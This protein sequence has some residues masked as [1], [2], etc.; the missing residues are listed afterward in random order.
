[1]DHS[2]NQIT[3]TKEYIKELL[4]NIPHSP[5]VYKMKNEHGDIIYVGK[6]KD[7]KNR[8]SSYF[9]ASQDKTTKTI[10]M[11][12]Q[13][14]DIDIITVQSELEAIML[15]T[16]LIK[17]YRPKY[18]ILMKDDKYFVYLKITVNEAFPRVEIVRKIQNDKAKYFGP[19]TAKYKILDALKVLKKIFPFRH[20]NLN[21]TYN[22][23]SDPRV[24]VSNASI[25]YPCLDYHINRCQA[26]CIGNISP[27]DYR[28]NINNIIDFF[29]GNQSK[30]IW[31]LKEKMMS[32]AQNKKFEQAAQIRD[33]I[34]SIEDLSEKQIISTTNLN[35][36]DIINFA[37][38]DERIFFNLFSVRKGKL[39]DQE[40][41]IFQSS[42]LEAE[43]N[44]EIV[45]AF[46]SQYYAE[47][48]DLPDEILVPALP[49][50]EEKNALEEWLREKKGKK[51]KL[52]SP[53]RGE[54]DQ[55]LELSFKNALSY[56]KQC[57]IK[58]LGQKKNERITALEDLKQILNLK[59]LPNRIECYDISHIQG[60]NTVSSMVVFEN[61]FPKTE[62]YRRF[63]LKTDDNPGSPN[64]FASMQKTLYRRA[65][66]LN[67]KISEY[68]VKKTTNKDL[69][70]LND[71][72]D[73][74]IEIIQKTKAKKNERKNSAI[75]N[76]VVN[77]TVI[78]NSAIDNVVI[79]NEETD[80]SVVLQNTQTTETVKE[81]QNE[82]TTGSS[83]NSKNQNNQQ[84]EKTTTT[85]YLKILSK[86]TLTGYIKLICS[87][88]KVL[89]SEINLPPTELDLD[90][91]LQV[92]DKIKQNRLYLQ[93]KRENLNN[94]LEFGFQ[95]INKIPEEYEKGLIEDQM[96]IVLD[97]NKFQKD[98][99]FVK[100][101]DL[102]VIDGGKG[103][104]SSAV[105]SLKDYDLDIPI[106]SLAKREE[107]IYQPEIS[108]PI[109]V[110]KDQPV[111]HLLQHIRD[112]AHRF[113]ITYQRNLRIK[114]ETSS[115]LDEIP[116]IGKEKAKKIL[117][118]FG[119][120]ENIKPTKHD[121]LVQIIGEKAAQALLKKLSQ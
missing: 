97:K 114:S 69:K 29:E 2:K 56:A 3:D 80:N 83:D 19:K 57:E 79:D 46:I 21:L 78:D 117:Q 23:D 71:Q 111:I 67:P 76:E 107:E 27:E 13:I 96:I 42:Q 98:K 43:S 48:A 86:D 44:E 85:E 65:K 49:D 88:Q 47:S 118:T 105:K 120:I 99:S 121:D 72:F 30:I 4:K 41:F 40:N 16:N 60:T 45:T 77:N 110:E 38:A 33:K 25:K 54:K 34:Q 87:G 90:F 103:Q 112:E 75:D 10:K 51:V 32:L 82:G 64:D 63:R 94:Y 12:E 89:I 37:I 22:P 5:G 93:C 31:E 62:D 91:F 115:I 92:F 50:E 95:E 61:G 100:K 53:E 84:P 35:D 66:Y 81:N 104:L 36:I 101:P 113:A 17:E 106:I 8:V 119:S 109:I 26:P 15:E 58:F 6:A 70:E 73:L 20:C 28:N 18:N 68:V 7:L 55:L 24:E 9:Q 39:N 108:A 116:G 102:I 11:V 1:M 74:K 52:L 14:R 59:N